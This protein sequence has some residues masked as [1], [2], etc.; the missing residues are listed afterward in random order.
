[1]DDDTYIKAIRDQFVYE[2]LTFAFGTGRFYGENEEE[3]IGGFNLLKENYNSLPIGFYI[4][5]GSYVTEVFDNFILLSHEHGF[6]Q[7]I[8]SKIFNKTHEPH[9]EDG[10][11]VLDLYKLSAGFI[12][13]LGSVLV[14][15]I[16]FIGELIV[17]RYCNQN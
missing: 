15:C 11:K 17:N 14:A 5:P 12:I 6:I 7:L 16:V 4:T 10:P 13:W 3:K 1:M 2:N 9:T 8:E